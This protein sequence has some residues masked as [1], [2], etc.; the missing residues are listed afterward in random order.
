MTRPGEPRDGDEGGGRGH[1]ELLLGGQ[2]T[3]LRLCD[4]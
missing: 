1:T 2:G 4:A 3:P